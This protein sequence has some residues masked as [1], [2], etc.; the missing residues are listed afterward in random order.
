M[1]KLLPFFI[2]F[3]LTGIIMHA[4]QV[5][6]IGSG[7]SQQPGPISGNYASERMVTIYTPSDGLMQGTVLSI[8]WNKPSSTWLAPNFPVKIYL[9]EV[10]YSTL[11]DTAS[12]VW[13]TLI[14]GATL[15]YQGV[16][17]WLG[18]SIQWVTIPLQATFSY[19]GTNNLMVLVASN[20]GGQTGRTLGWAYTPSGSLNNAYARG[21]AMNDDISFANAG[22]RDRNA[23]RPNIQFGIDPSST[24][25]TPWNVQ[26]SS[27]SARTATINW[28]SR[29]TETQ[30]LLSYK[31]STSDT[32]ADDIIVSSSSYSFTTL[33]PNTTYMVKIKAKC[34]SGN[35]DTSY[36]TVPSSFTTS[37][38]VS[39]P[40][41]EGFE[42]TP[43]TNPIAAPVCWSYFYTPYVGSS[44]VGTGATPFSGIRCYQ[45]NYTHVA[46]V[47]QKPLLISPYFEE[48]V[49]SLRVRFWAKAAS[50]SDSVQV[51]YMTN[52]LDT[53]T[54]RVVNAIKLS[55]AWAE[56][57]ARFDTV[58]T[59]AHYIAFSSKRS[60]NCNVYLDSVNIDV[61]SPCP[62][63]FALAMTNVTSDSV[64]LKFTST[65]T[66][67]NIAYRIA[68]TET[69]FYASRN[70]TVTG[71]GGLAPSTD[72]EVK[73][74]SACNDG[75]SVGE[76][77]VPITFRTAQMYASLTYSEN[78]EDPASLEWTFVNGSQPNKWYVGDATHNEIGTHS[79]YITN[80]NGVSNEYTIGTASVTHMYRDFVFS[81]ADEYVLTFD[82][83]AEGEGTTSAM[84]YLRVNLI[85][86]NVLP[87]AGTAITTGY[88][89]QYLNFS[90]GWKRQQIV[91]P[92]TLAGKTKRLVFSWINNA[93]GG[94]QPP[95]AIDNVL[96]EASNCKTPSN[97]RASGMTS[98]SLDI[99]WT[100]TGTN[101]NITYREKGTLAWLPETAS[102]TTYTIE[103][104]NPN[105]TYE[106]RVQNNCGGTNISPWTGT[107]E[108]KTRCIPPTLPLLESFEM[109]STSNPSAPECW[110]YIKT[111]VNANTNAHNSLFH[112]GAKGYYLKHDASSPTTNQTMLI[113]PILAEDIST[114]QV[115]FWARIATANNMLKIGYITNPTDAS[116]F[117]LVDTVPFYDLSWQVNTWKQHITKFDTVSPGT[118]YSIA[119][120][121]QRSSSNTVYIDDIMIAPIPVCTTPITGIKA[122]NITTTS[123]EITFN[124]TGTTYELKYREMGTEAWIT[125]TIS[126]LPYTITELLPQ[127]RY[128]Y[129]IR[130]QCEDG[131]SDWFEGEPFW[132][133]FELPYTQNF[134]LGNIVTIYD[135][136]AWEVLKSNVSGGGVYLESGSGNYVSSPRSVYLYN[137]MTG[138]APFY[139]IA[140]QM[141]P[142]NVAG[143][144]Q[145]TFKAKANA[146]QGAS[147]AVGTIKLGDTASF[148]RIDSIPLTNIWN[149]YMVNFENY[150]G[151]DYHIA[152]GHIGNA[153][154]T[155]IYLDDIKIES[156]GYCQ[157]ISNLQ[158]DNITS[159]GF[160]LNWQDIQT[161]YVI[162]YWTD[163]L[164][165]AQTITATTNSYSFTGLTPM[166]TYKFK[167][168][169]V[170]YQDIWTDTFAV[171]TLQI[172]AGLPFAESFE[173]STSSSQWTIVNGEYI[174]KWYIDT[175]AHAGAS[176]RSA[177]ISDN[178]GITNRY[179][180]NSQGTV[181]VY[182]DIVFPQTTSG[183]GFDFS[184]DWRGEGNTAFGNMA[185]F[186]RV[187]FVDIDV[188]PVAGT[189]L[190]TGILYDLQ[191][192]SGWRHER[193]SFPDTLAGQTKRLVFTWRNGGMG[194]IQ[195][196]AAIDNISLVANDPPQVCLPVEDVLV[197][198]MGTT[199]IT[200]WTPDGDQNKWEII[201]MEGESVIEEKIV[202]EYLSD[203]IQGLTRGSTYTVSVR[204]ICG[205]GDT[206]E[207]IFSIPF[208][209]NVCNMVRDLRVE[210]CPSKAIATWTALSGQSE[211]ELLYKTQ[212]EDEIV[213][214][215]V[216]TNKD[217]LTGLQEGVTYKL[218]I[219]AICSPY[220]TSIFTDP[221]IFTTPACMPLDTVVVGRDPG[222]DSI[223]VSWNNNV[224]HQY[225]QISVVSVGS[226]P[227]DMIDA[228]QSTGVWVKIPD[229][230]V[231]YDVYVRGVCGEN[232]YSDWKYTTTISEGIN[233]RIDISP[234][235]IILSPNPAH[236]YTQLSIENANGEVDIE[237]ITLEGKVL[238]KERVNCQPKL[239]KQ[240]VLQ[241]LS[242]GVY[243]I[244]LTHKDWT[245]S[246]K[247][248]VQ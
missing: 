231:S 164:D 161:N 213:R 65:G 206:S 26:T 41:I 111:N 79:A 20:D 6:S 179:A 170:C 100:S 200:T 139:W 30:W 237:L 8:A 204:N 51:G 175:A 118:G 144:V 245:K 1:K 162:E 244:R 39:L 72:Y 195:T 92:D 140:P 67:F 172:P 194:G 146:A 220:D 42:S 70:A 115:K 63:V 34:G 69:W 141:D 116:T 185:D 214:K 155:S 219:R 150:I 235:K 216:R 16:P 71:V 94:T 134:D 106:I 239:S 121:A 15:V 156:L 142:Q 159:S 78:F 136:D 124:Q 241:N 230:N 188:V 211:W 44:L 209:I 153:N 31:T 181:H 108:A 83:K 52:P 152:F 38:L 95:A 60:A 223:L 182:R 99:S 193:I 148:T 43:T 123:A 202:E 36:S 35:A 76:W 236:D 110:R 248:I 243:L 81:Q 201:Y 73:V 93:G 57:V 226:T 218:Q 27:I 191:Y 90:N 24:C 167:M 147:V 120:S 98:T 130:F 233:P 54:F 197:N 49:S 246:Q 96:F 82:W 3:M 247:L 234:V 138:T 222:A 187:N 180:T 183:N 10:S 46:S 157:G 80:D 5:V 101:F 132:T 62:N 91:L 14:N 238:R 242:K 75:G 151:G 45:L 119:F 53:S 173:D 192:S 154:Y 85:D 163:G 61:A 186:L 184:F 177:Y 105:T 28:T 169:P 18:S 189:I 32:W 149:T 55:T 114:L 117:H 23:N 229:A 208:T 47:A 89:L 50:T 166:T 210:A 113:S 165:D 126:S 29:G 133:A 17:T 215:I 125:R 48:N 21:A 212:D 104:L 127:K 84:D 131:Q 221:K 135:I 11:P 33:S 203:T 227:G 2:A 129:I 128:E 7:T 160:D 25:P 196:P 240:I 103:N 174:N 158:I 168:M 143:T 68:N 97:L 86:V 64:M 19:S 171:T 228:Y 176:G 112:F 77:S 232:S 4:Q 199:A 56:Y 217:T 9:K 145:L 178:N 22:F 109:T 205:D 122:Q 74:Q 190:T 66:N 224:C 59:S 87:V 58:A 12:L 107:L 102:T 40:I 137:S 207:A 13:N 37:C 88:L 225:W 198:T